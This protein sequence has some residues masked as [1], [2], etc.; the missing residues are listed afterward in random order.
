MSIGT[1]RE[2]FGPEEWNIRTEAP[3]M[4]VLILELFYLK[5]EGELQNKNKSQNLLGEYF[6]LFLSVWN[7]G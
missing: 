4:K 7:M 2:D 3:K 1:V 6:V 5:V